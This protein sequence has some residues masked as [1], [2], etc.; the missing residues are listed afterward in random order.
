D[1]IYFIEWEGDE[2]PTGGR[3]EYNQ[4]E[5]GLLERDTD[6][7]VIDSFTYGRFYSDTICATT[8]RECDFFKRLIAGEVESFRLLKEFTY[9]LPPYLPQV[10][11]TAVNPDIL[12]FER[13][14]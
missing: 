12:I 9:R 4:A 1:P 8:P 14:R 2:V 11:L 5:K 6:Y 7:F 13:V 3:F 10:T